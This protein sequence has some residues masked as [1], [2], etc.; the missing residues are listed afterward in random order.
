MDLTM[1]NMRGIE[2]TKKIL[3]GNPTAKILEL[4]MV[5]D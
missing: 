5:L 4:S 3:A 2:A 1:P